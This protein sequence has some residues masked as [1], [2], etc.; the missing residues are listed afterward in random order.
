[1]VTLQLQQLLCRR[2]RAAIVQPPL[3]LWRRCQCNILA[4]VVHCPGVQRNL[5]TAVACNVMP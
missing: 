3:A 5:V 4:I 2:T 1:M